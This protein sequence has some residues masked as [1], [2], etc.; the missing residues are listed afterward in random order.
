MFCDP[1]EGVVAIPR[2]LLE[3]VVA[4]MPELVAA[5]GKVKEDVRRGG[6]VAAAFEKHRG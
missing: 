5:D 2:S 4:L 3:E 6:S 1:W